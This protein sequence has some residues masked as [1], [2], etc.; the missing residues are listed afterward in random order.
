M[1]SYNYIQLYSVKE[2]FF[3]LVRYLP[4]KGGDDSDDSCH[5]FPILKGQVFSGCR[6][7]AW[8]SGYK[9][10]YQKAFWVFFRCTLWMHQNLGNVQIIGAISYQSQL[11][12]FFS[13]INFLLGV[14]FQPL[15]VDDFFGMKSMWP[16][17]RSSCR[18]GCLGLVPLANAPGTLT[19][20]LAIAHTSK[21]L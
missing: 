5:W 13:K 2:H 4:L 3:F 19:T 17:P 20:S 12:Q 1:T 11:V 15:E 16:S 7:T 18:M 6:A 21:C 9:A 8:A 14:D 10:V